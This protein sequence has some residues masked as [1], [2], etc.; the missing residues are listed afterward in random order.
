MEKGWLGQSILRSRKPASVQSSFKL[1]KKGWQQLKAQFNRTPDVRHPSTHAGSPSDTLLQLVPVLHRSSYTGPSVGKFG[2]AEC[3]PD[4]PIVPMGQPSLGI[5]TRSP[6]PAPANESCCGSQPVETDCCGRQTTQ[7]DGCGSQTTGTACC[8]ELPSFK[9]RLLKETFGAI[10]MVGK[11]MALAFVLEALITLY[12]PA[13][14][15]SASLGSQSPL[16]IISAALLGIPAYTT[17]LTALPMISGLLNQGM[18]PAAA[19]AFLIAGPTTTLP[20]MA[21]VW[22][23]VAR[24]VFVMYV[25][26]AL[27][28]A[29]LTGVCY[30]LLA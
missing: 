22:P 7:T 15:I 26:F 30:S 9:S 3:A 18:N 12:V 17:S 5:G 8:D 2:C 23:L 6:I 4:T 29:V 25:S 28:G 24:R 21:A 27:V 20:A 14:W 19:I 10:W 16:A 13:N 11:F 1:L